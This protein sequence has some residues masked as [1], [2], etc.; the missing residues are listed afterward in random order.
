MS[1]TVSIAQIN[2]IVG[3]FRQNLKMV[4]EAI[5]QAKNESAD[6][7]VFPELALTGYPP[8]DLFLSLSALIKDLCL[9]YNLSLTIVL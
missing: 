7:I 8:E 6:I 4:S 3:S 1:V 9:P 2:P 5:A